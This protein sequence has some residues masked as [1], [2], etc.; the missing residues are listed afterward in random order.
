MQM[1]EI[2][3]Y[4]YMPVMSLGRPMDAPELSFLREQQGMEDLKHFHVQTARFEYGLD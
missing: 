3:A 4:G 2:M 1:E